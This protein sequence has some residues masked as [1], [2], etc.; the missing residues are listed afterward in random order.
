MPC[1][2]FPHRVAGYLPRVPRNHWISK[3]G[4]VHKKV[5][6]FIGSEPLELTDADGAFG[7]DSADF[8]LSP[9]RGCPGIECVQDPIWPPGMLDS[10]LPH[11]IVPGSL[12]ARTV[13]VFEC[14][15]DS[16]SSFTYAPHTCLL[17]CCKIV[18]P[19]TELIGELDITCHPV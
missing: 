19:V 6:S 14:H 9:H 5:A 18:P 12:D 8:Q 3:L 13:R 2:D 16:S 15:T 10:Q 1:Q 7:K 17:L 11:L 4:G